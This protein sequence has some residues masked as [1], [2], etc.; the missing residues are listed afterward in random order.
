AVVAEPIPP[1]TPHRRRR[2]PAGRGEAFLVFAGKGG[3]GKSMVATNLAV[4]LRMATQKATA[5]VDLDL[6]FGDIGLMLGVEHHSESI[7]ILAHHGELVDQELL[8]RVMVSGP[9]GVRA[10][11]APE[12]PELAE[13]ITPPALRAILRELRRSVDFMLIDGPAQLNEQI[14]EVIDI[15]DHILVVTS[16]SLTAVKDTRI[17][18]TLLRSL[19]VDMDRISVILNQTR[20]RSTLLREDVEERLGMRIRTQL[21]FEHRIVDDA[22]DRGR[23][24]VVGEPEAE[25]TR[26]VH[27]LAAFLATPVAADH[28]DGAATNGPARMRMHPFRRRFGVGRREQPSEVGRTP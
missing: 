12:A 18:I 28:T 22:I 26:R 6:Q 23:P 27:A 1:L 19:G 20:A 13:L 11:L 25:I 8:T 16:F 5:L 10:L 4:A 9:E 2:T 17:M 14:L 7:E 21:P 24:F 3:V 15:A